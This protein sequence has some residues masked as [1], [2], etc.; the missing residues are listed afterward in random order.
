[1]ILCIVRKG[2]WTIHA[3]SSLLKDLDGLD[4]HEK[5]KILKLLSTIADGDRNPQQLPDDRCHQID[6]GKKLWQFRIGNIRIPWFYD[7][8]KI[9][10]CSHVFIKKC[11]KTPQSE[12]LRATKL[13]QEYFFHKKNGSLLIKGETE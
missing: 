7:E 5:N 2:I 12:I 9:V 4:K 8:G 6:A 10:V 13:K 3:D 11:Q 1:M